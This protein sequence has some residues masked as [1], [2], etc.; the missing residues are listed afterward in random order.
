MP[1]SDLWE[2][3][4]NALIPR[5]A[6]GRRASETT[7]CARHR[8]AALPLGVGRATGTVRSSDSTSRG[9]D[10]PT[11]VLARDSANLPSALLTVGLWNVVFIG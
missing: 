4:A 7:Q 1:P 5:V 10:H 2:T 9:A 6:G 3:G 8:S 11:L